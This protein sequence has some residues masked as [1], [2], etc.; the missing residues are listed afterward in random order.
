[1][2]H[3]KKKLSYADI[4]CR[5]NLLSGANKLPIRT[6]SSLNP[7][8]N[9]GHISVFSRISWPN[10][11]DCSRKYNRSLHPRYQARFQSRNRD[12]ASVKNRGN[13]WWFQRSRTVQSS[14]LKA[15]G[16]EPMG[17]EPTQPDFWPCNDCA[18]SG[19]QYTICKSWATCFKCYKGAMLWPIA[20][21]TGGNM[22]KQYRL[23]IKKRFGLLIFCRIPGRLVA[24]LLIFNQKLIS[25]PLQLTVT[26]HFP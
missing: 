8:S 23:P 5:R 20:Q 19:L 3:G 1:V 9:R 4:V 26:L 25:C 13:Q 17:Q 18:S 24:K 15:K 14:N 12:L 21:P 6:K 10:E 11:V 7:S 2:I 22:G 16:K